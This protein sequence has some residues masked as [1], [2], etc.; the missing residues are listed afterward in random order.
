MKNM[1]LENIAK[2]CNGTYYG[3]EEKKQSE[4]AG[5]A[6]D[7]RI[8]QKDWLFVATKGERVDGHSFIPDVV[9][10]GA[11]CVISE[12]ELADA[13][14]TYIVVKDSFQALKDIAGFYREQMKLPVI[15]ITGSVG[16]T[17]T[18]E[19][20]AAVVSEKYNTLK[21]EGNF[22]NEV[23]VPLT[24]F[25]LRD[26]H[27]AAVVEMGISDFGE[28]HRLSEIV[29]PD[30][31]VITN[32]GQCHLENLGDR[33][34]VL[35]AKTEIFDFMKEDAP[36]ILNGDD[37]KLAGINQKR[38]DMTY[39]SK[40]AKENSLGEIYAKN[41][42]AKGILGTDCEIYTPKGSFFVHIPIPGEHMVNNALAA[43][44]VGLKLSLTLDEIK[45]GIEKVEALPGRSHLILTEMYTILDD[46]YNANPVSMK[47]AV[48]LLAETEGRRCA[49][50]GSMFELG[51]KI[52]TWAVDKKIEV[53]IS[54]GELGKCIYEGAL[55]RKEEFLTDTELFYF[56]TVEEFLNS[57]ESI[58][59]KQ[60]AL[61][62][63]ASHGMKFAQIV[64]KLSKV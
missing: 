25:R 8:I 52:G 9:K 50:L 31:C 7:S 5:I 44:A 53:I 56:E 37:D 54:I 61:L 35:R 32:I 2:A 24:L 60:D 64:D 59:K 14:Y 47:A 40:E 63:K 58:L 42:Q 3:E 41:I 48:S 38:K 19:M 33:D 15:G 46:C 12:K 55:A 4:V 6:I 57:C 11:L 1:T 62:I 45:R 30:L 29:K 27:E 36:V 18:K 22:N 28:M 49:I 26:E 13:N 10:K 39:F 21:T 17:S 20:I 43:T 51:E 16:K 23:G 34:G